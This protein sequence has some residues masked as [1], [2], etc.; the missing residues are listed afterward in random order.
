LKSIVRGIPCEFSDES[1]NDN[2]SKDSRIQPT[3]L[4]MTPERVVPL[5]GKSGTGIRKIL[6]PSSAWD[7]NQQQLLEELCAN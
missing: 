7:N 2:D 5:R 6:A 4:S 3:D 1:L